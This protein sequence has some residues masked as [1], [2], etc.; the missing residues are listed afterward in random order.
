MKKHFFFAL[1]SLIATLQ[2]G[3][4]WADTSKPDSVHPHRVHLIKKA[5]P[6]VPEAPAVDEVLS[7]A[8]LAAAMLVNRGD[9]QCEFNQT[10]SVRPDPQHAGLFQVSFDK[11][12]YTM[13]PEPTTTGA[14]RL[15]DRRAG[16]VWLQIPTKSMLMNSAKGQRMVDACTH[17]E[18]RAVVAANAVTPGQAGPGIGIVPVLASPV[19]ANSGRAPLR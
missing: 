15:E 14:V 7:E 10:I 13:T 1:V 9:A 6:P 18:Q 3:A 19:V 4:A 17:A 8:Q 11:H 2:A 5:P 16:V 12:T